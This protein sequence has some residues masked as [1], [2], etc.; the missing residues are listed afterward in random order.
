MLLLTVELLK[1]KRSTVIPKKTRTSVVVSLLFDHLRKKPNSAVSAVSAQILSLE[2]GPKH[3]L[4]ASPPP[5]EVRQLSSIFVHRFHIQLDL[6]F[7]PWREPQ[8]C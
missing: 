5:V 1:M 6:H 7:G 2:R 4:T 8:R 3:T